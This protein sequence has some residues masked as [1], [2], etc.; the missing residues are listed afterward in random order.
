VSILLAQ[1]NPWLYPSA[2]KPTRLQRALARA[3]LPLRVI[4]ELGGPSENTL[5]DWKHRG[6]SAD[7]ASIK[8]LAAA[9]ARHGRRLLRLARLLDA[10]AS[11]LPPRRRGRPPKVD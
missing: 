10:W 3:R 4:E 8:R 5:L 2:M 6:R 7:P 11:A 1:E 9:L